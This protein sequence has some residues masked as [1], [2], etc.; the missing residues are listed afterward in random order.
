[1][2]KS[3]LAWK[4][5]LFPQAQCLK[6]VVFF[7]TGNICT[8]FVEC[9]FCPPRQSCRC[10]QLFSVSFSFLANVQGQFCVGDE[11]QKP[12]PQF[13]QKKELHFFRVFRMRLRA[14]MDTPEMGACQCIQHFLL[15]RRNTSVVNFSEDCQFSEVYFSYNFWAAIAERGTLVCFPGQL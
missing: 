4:I 7:C 15:G 11:E 9:Y 10:F 3:E 14:G 1:M 2:K 8:L 5:L 6:D 13:S 12:I